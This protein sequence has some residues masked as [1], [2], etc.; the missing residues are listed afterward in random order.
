MVNLCLWD[1]DDDAPK[2][3]STSETNI[4]SKTS[5]S[6]LQ[7][8]LNKDISKSFTSN[9]QKASSQVENTQ[10]LKI[11][12]I[13]TGG[14][15]RLSGIDFSQYVQVNF[16]SIN[17][18]SVKESSKTKMLTSILNNISKNSDTQMQDKL[19]AAVSAA[20]GLPLI[21]EPPA[22]SSATKSV[23]N[24]HTEMNVNV[25][26]YVANVVEK[27]TEKMNVQDC[28]KELKNTQSIEVEDVE[29]T[30]DF[31]ID[32]IKMEQVAD[33]VMKCKSVNKVSADILTE[34]QNDLGTTIKEVEKT[35]KVSDQSATTEATTGSAEIMKGIGGGFKF[36][37]MAMMIA[38]IVGGIVCLSI[39]GI[40]AYKMMPSGGG[41]KSGGRRLRLQKGG[42]FGMNNIQPIIIIA[43]IFLILK[44]RQRKESFSQQSKFETTVDGRKYYLA[45]TI[46]C[47]NCEKTL[48]LSSDSNKATRFEIK[49]GILVLDDICVNGDELGGLSVIMSQDQVR[50]SNIEFEGEYLSI[51]HL[52]NERIFC[53]DDDEIVLGTSYDD[54][55]EPLQFKMI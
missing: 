31:T 52:Q 41:A 20:S 55:E 48:V 33:A 14:A 27:H 47:D 26:N 30:G 11:K 18:N 15:F 54:V 50:L 46:N 16:D 12:K 35:K 6:T 8:T 10:S 22:A 23:L 38:P 53:T 36:A 25:K 17:E 39:I 13:R 51:F 40:I 3:E 21:D 44:K 32:L 9:V 45:K 42:F 5:V 4:T 28:S 7:E 29:A 1:C 2:A 37:G 24:K 19:S 49:D 43:I 34:M